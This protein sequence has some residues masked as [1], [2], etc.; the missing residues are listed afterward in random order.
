[1]KK[2]YYDTDGDLEVF[3]KRFLKRLVFLILGYGI[4]LVLCAIL[5]K[6]IFQESYVDKYTS[7][8]VTKFLWWDIAML[9]TLIILTVVLTIFIIRH[10]REKEFPKWV[11]IPVIAFVCLMI[12]QIKDIS[13]VFLDM[14]HE[15]YV[16][17]QGEF[18]QDNSGYS[19]RSK[20]TKLLSSDM[21]LRSRKSLVSD[22]NHTGIVVYTE[23]SKIALEVIVESPS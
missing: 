23:C 9:I 16:V 1:M 8:I 15:S 22:G 17:Y 11:I 10:I 7:I 13:D 12:W 19:L 3:S 6:N 4:L 2:Q 18:I 21:S 20:N 14:K 5:I